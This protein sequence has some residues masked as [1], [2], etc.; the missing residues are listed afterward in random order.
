V[1]LGLGRRGGG[2]VGMSGRSESVGRRRRGEAGLGTGTGTG[3]AEAVQAEARSCSPTVVPHAGVPCRK[4]ASQPLRHAGHS[5]PNR[6]RKE[7][8]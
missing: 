7:N 4:P 8:F 3:G 2:V 6:D 5:G 1:K